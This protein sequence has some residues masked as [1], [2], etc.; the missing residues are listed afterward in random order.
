MFD[1]IP[2]S[3]LKRMA[4]PTLLQSFYVEQLRLILSTEN[5]YPSSRRILNATDID[6]CRKIFDEFPEIIWEKFDF[7]HRIGYGIRTNISVRPLLQLCYRQAPLDLIQRA[8]NQRT[9]TNKE[10]NEKR[11]EVLS[12]VD[13]GNYTPLHWAC[14]GTLITFGVIKFLVDEYPTSLYQNTWGHRS[15][16]HHA[17]ENNLVVDIVKFL[18]IRNPGQSLSRDNHQNLP[19]HLACGSQASIEV[20]KLLAEDEEISINAQSQ[21]GLRESHSGI[22]YRSVSLGISSTM[23]YTPL[24]YACGEGASLEVVRYLVR[25]CPSALQT[26]GGSMALPLHLACSRRFPMLNVIAFLVARFPRALML[27]T[28]DGCS[29]EYG[30]GGTPIQLAAKSHASLELIKFLYEQCPAALEGPDGRRTNVAVQYACSSG[31]SPDVIEFLLGKAFIETYDGLERMKDGKTLLHATC[32]N[33]DSHCLVRAILERFP[34]DI[35][36]PSNSGDLPLHSACQAHACLQVVRYMIE[37]YP[38]ALRIVNKD[39]N[40]PLHR[41]F[42]GCSNIRDVDVPTIRFLAEQSEEALLARNY[43]DMTPFHLATSLLFRGKIL[44]PISDPSKNEILHILTPRSSDFKKTDRSKCVKLPLHYMVSGP[45]INSN[46]V[47]FFIEHESTAFLVANDLGDTPLHVAS[48]TN[49]VTLFI[50]RKL[51][52]MNPDAMQLPNLKGLFPFQLAASREEKKENGEN[53]RESLEVIYFLVQRS[54]F[55]FEHLASVP[56]QLTKRKTSRI[57]DIHS[58][59]LQP[60]PLTSEDILNQCVKKVRE[61]EGKFEILEKGHYRK[62]G[63]NSSSCCAVS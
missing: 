54:L 44:F 20:V 3:S 41:F 32:A 15:C 60:D 47:D 5:H 28:S 33:L 29:V 16:L 14:S 30:G 62:G 10:S 48:G 7:G 25:Q 53:D 43:Q 36:V 40:L 27:S 57:D 26:L 31:A 21:L 17:C 8:C 52:H 49:G 58:K 18:L 35:A 2:T 23:G 24:H 12:E 4:S 42:S 13:G 56:D 63:Y 46:G 55:A 45:P 9:Q 39:G 59:E 11:M 51:F 38:K 61:L 37:R 19:L 50:V 34:D 22:I 6:A 1:A